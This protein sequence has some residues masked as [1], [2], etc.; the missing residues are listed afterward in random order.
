MVDPAYTYFINFDLGPCCACGKTG[1]S[2]RNI[3]ALPFKAPQPG[4][5]WGCT[6]CALP[7]DGAFAVVCDHCLHVHTPLQFAVDGLVADKGR[8]PIEQ[9]CE[10]FRHDKHAHAGEIKPMPKKKSKKQRRNQQRAK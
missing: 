7:L 3:V 6:T 4:T 5:G 10:P 1:H 9:L 8:T 2:V